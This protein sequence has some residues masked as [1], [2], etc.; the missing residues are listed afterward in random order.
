MQQS[1]S[2]SYLPGA[3]PERQ[4]ADPVPAASPPHQPGH[5]TAAA[6]AGHAI[7]T[8]DATSARHG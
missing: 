3:D 8:A 1:S 4:D 2:E 5:P 6:S 7:P